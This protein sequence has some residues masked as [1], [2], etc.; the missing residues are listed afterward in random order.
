MA[1]MD[2]M[3]NTLREILKKILLVALGSGLATNALYIYGLA[4]YQGYINRFGFEYGFFPIEWED[5][6]MWTYAASREFGVTTVHWW[7]K[8]GLGSMSIMLLTIYVIARMWMAATAENKP[9]KS[10]FKKKS[11]G[12]L[13]T[14]AEIRRSY[15]RTFD[16]IRWFFNA[17]Q[18]LW[19]FVVSYFALIVIFCVPLFIMIWVYFPLIGMKHGNDIAEKRLAWYEESLCADEDDYWDECVRVATTHIGN[20]DLPGHQVGRLILKHQ[21]YLGLLTQ[22]GPVTMTM[23]KEFYQMAVAKDKV[24]RP[25]QDC[26]HKSTD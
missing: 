20:P 4:F 9:R 5:A 2:T 10:L 23:P 17:E 13:R 14:L 1:N 3:P 6:L 24:E 11:F 22:C 18:S 19:A 26:A 21:S 12:T 15:P 16:T 7:T 8:L 25:V